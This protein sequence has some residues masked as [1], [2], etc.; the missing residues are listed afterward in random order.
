MQG[1]KGS[2]LLEKVGKMGHFFKAQG[3]SYLRHIPPGL[4]E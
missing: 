4:F 2:M 3:V 1:R